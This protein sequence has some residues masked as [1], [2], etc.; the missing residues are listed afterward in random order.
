MFK[1]Q[2][3]MVKQFFSLQNPT[4]VFTPKTAEKNTKRLITIVNLR[5]LDYIDKILI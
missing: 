3:P 2:V 4:R 5:I 1:F